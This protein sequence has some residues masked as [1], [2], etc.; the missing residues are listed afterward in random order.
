MEGRA[1]THR[2]GLDKRALFDDLG[3]RPHDGQLAVHLS[4]ASRRIL[5][6]GVRW[7]KSTCAAL[8][9]V[10]AALQPCE[11]SLGWIVGPTYEL[12]SRVFREVEAILTEHLPHRVEE[13]NAREHRL[14]IRNLAGGISEVRSKSAD[15]PV[16]L[17]GEGLSWVIVD[18][19]ARL[20]RDIWEGHVSQRLIDRQ[21]WALLLSTPRGPGWFQEIWA[22]GQGADPYYASWREPSWSSPFLKREVIERERERLAPE[23]FDQEYGAVFVGVVIPCATCGFPVE[24]ATGILVFERGAEISRCAECG[25]ELDENGRCLRWPDPPGEGSLTTIEIVSHVDPPRTVVMPGTPEGS[26]T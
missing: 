15:H 1:P 4:T 12:A 3:Y 14:L 20:R 21:G 10:A 8:E 5:A 9:G 7:G 25:K 2:L 13:V 26:E 18:E 11:E 23:V 6:C 22:R 19:A 17:L 24:G 16:S